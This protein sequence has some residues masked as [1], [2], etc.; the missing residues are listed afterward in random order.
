MLHTVLLENISKFLGKLART[1]EDTYHRH[2]NQPNTESLEHTVAIISQMKSSPHPVP[3][4][5]VV[6]TNA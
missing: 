6:D 4:L 1:L 5:I 3:C 2:A